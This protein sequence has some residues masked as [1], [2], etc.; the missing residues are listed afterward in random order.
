M[1][2]AYLTQSAMQMAKITVNNAAGFEHTQQQD[3]Q[4]GGGKGEHRI[5]Q[6][7]DQSIQ[8]AAVVG[9]KHAHNDADNTGNVTTEKPT[10][11]DVRSP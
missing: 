8:Q 2:R 10:I 7:H 6:A 1:V 4:Q 11:S 9:G 3:G 5:G